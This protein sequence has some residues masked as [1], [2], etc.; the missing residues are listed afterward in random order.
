MPKPPLPKQ[1]DQAFVESQARVRASILESMGPHGGLTLQELDAAAAQH[2]A[3]YASR[4]AQL[5]VLPTTLYEGYK[6]HLA[7]PLGVDGKALEFVQHRA[8][9]RAYGGHNAYEEARA[10]GRTKLGYQQWVQVR[11]PDFKNWF[12]DWEALRAQLRLDAQPAVEVRI[13]DAWRSLGVEDLRAQMEIVLDAMVR[14]RATIKHP[15]LGEIRVGRAGAKKSVST[16]RD[17]AKSF[18]VADLEALLPASIYARSEPSRG[19]DG[20]DI[21]G[22]S[23]L[24]TPVSV[25]EVQLLAAFTVRHQSDG[26][27]YYNA[28]TLHAGREKGR[29]QDSY[30]RPD[31]RNGGSRFAPIAGLA[32]FIRRPLVRVNESSVSKVLDPD[33]LEPLVVYRNFG[34]EPGL[35]SF[36]DS[37]AIGKVSDLGPQPGIFGGPVMPVFLCVRN[38]SKDGEGKDLADSLVDGAFVK[39]AGMVEVNVRDLGQVK[40]A[41]PEGEAFIGV[42]GSPSPTSRLVSWF[43]GADVRAIVKDGAYF[44]F[45]NDAHLACALVGKADRTVGEQQLLDDVSAL[46]AWHGL[47]GET[48]T[49]LDMWRYMDGTQAQGHHERIAAG[50]E[51]YIREGRAPTPALSDYF[52]AAQGWMLDVYGSVRNFLGAN[53]GAR[54]LSDEVRSAFDRVL[55]Y[56]S[57]I[58]AG[59]VPQ[60]A[61]GLYS[62]RILAI[63]DG[64]VV[65]KIGRSET[66]IVRYAAEVLDRPVAVGSVCDVLFDQDGRGTVSI[67]GQV[68]ER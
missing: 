6:E 39:G 54:E 53:P 41:I 13:P 2:T 40:A 48:A 51:Q 43:D 56:G 45:E 8:T 47:E 27:W 3:Y 7:T 61:P 10:A 55:E 62:G 9:E 18:V 24:L 16:G 30:G 66:D 29:A 12:G 21:D 67:Q 68:L 35:L 34:A 50:L 17:P 60:L 33:T 15:E 44:F 28:V 57:G 32:E 36:V 63:D 59:N 23:T 1:R 26:R 65:Q 25:D 52:E 46:F 19:N 42:E 37:P 22:Y 31:R 64:V 14:Q 49:Q 20:P 11:T 58:S 38:P 5:G 4:A